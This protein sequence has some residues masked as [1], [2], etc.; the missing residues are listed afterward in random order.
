MPPAKWFV[1]RRKNEIARKR[2]PILTN[3]SALTAAPRGYGI[4]HHA[5]GSSCGG[6]T[7]R[8]D[9]YDVALQWPMKG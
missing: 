2:S 3:N 8:K 6:L 5:D 7:N 4:R 1:T 9:F